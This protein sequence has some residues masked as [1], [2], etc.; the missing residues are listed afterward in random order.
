[1]HDIVISR[2]D[3]VERRDLFTISNERRELEGSPDIKRLLVC[4]LFARHPCCAELP[5][6]FSIPETVDELT[7]PRII[8]GVVL[9]EKRQPIPIPAPKRTVLAHARHDN[10]RIR[11]WLRIIRVEVKL[12][13]VAPE[14]AAFVRA[15]HDASMDFCERRVEVVVKARGDANTGG[16]QL[17]VAKVRCR[18]VCEPYVETYKIVELK[19]LVTMFHF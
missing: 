18:I 8:N 10:A 9:S 4:L 13:H 11:S 19:I 16:P 2:P 7:V 3:F 14:H 12:V 6:V 1:M 15:I 17:N 5:L